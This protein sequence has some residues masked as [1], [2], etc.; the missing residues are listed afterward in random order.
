[1]TGDTVVLCDTIVVSKTFIEKIKDY[2]NDIKQKKAENDL[3]G[4]IL[5]QYFSKAK[6]AGRSDISSAGDDKRSKDADAA[7]S[8]KKGKKGGGGGGSGNTQGR[9]IK[10]KAV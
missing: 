9:E 7:Q 4:G 8:G 3:K 5:L 10:V 6:T 1:F 2:F